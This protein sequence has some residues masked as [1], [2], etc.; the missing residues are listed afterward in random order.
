MS[1]SNWRKDAANSAL[2]VT[3]SRLTGYK[4]ETWL[5]LADQINI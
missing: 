5:T 3:A 4:L 1:A 2:F